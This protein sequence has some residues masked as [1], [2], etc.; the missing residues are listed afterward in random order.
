M[1]A[2]IKRVY[3]SSQYL[4]RK[5]V[6]I[7]LQHKLKKSELYALKVK[8]NNIVKRIAFSALNRFPLVLGIS[9]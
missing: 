2:W 8:I 1:E 9:G 6:A 4:L 3:C 7:Q 5:K